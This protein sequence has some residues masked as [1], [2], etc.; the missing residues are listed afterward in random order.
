M[1]RFGQHRLNVPR[2]MEK[3]DLTLSNIAW[4]IFPKQAEVFAASSAEIVPA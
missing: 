1:L 2:L 3:G 4:Q